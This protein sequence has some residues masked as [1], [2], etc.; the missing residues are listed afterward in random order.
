MNEPDGNTPPDALM[1]MGTHCPY[2]PSVL[3]ALQALVASGHIIHLETHNIEENPEIAR[4][5][6]VRSVPWVRIGPFE[7]EGLRSEKELR[8]WAVKAAANAGLT[9]W[10][11]ELLSSGNISKP[12]EHIKSD[13]AAMNTLLKLFADPDTKLNAQIGISAIMEDLKGTDT[14]SAIVDQLGEL[15]QHEDAR[16]RGDA[17]YYLAL[18]GSPKAAGF[19]KTRLDDSDANVREIAKESL[20]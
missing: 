10:L 2:C 9:D 12:L 16:V 20:E 1:L 17:C 18:S 7:L 13:P 19:I 11:N 15:T 14:L 5:F 8:E 3:K 6:G 4:E